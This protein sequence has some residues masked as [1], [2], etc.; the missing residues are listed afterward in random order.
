MNDVVI[1][2]AG[3]AGLAAAYELSLRGRHCVVLEQ[4]PRAGGVIFTERVDGFVID[5]GPDSL[6]VQ[7]PAA[8]DLAREIGLGDRLVETLKPR[9][10]YI[11]RDGRL[12]PLPEA[13][14]LGIPTT[15]RPFFTTRLFSWPAKLRMALELAIRPR[16][17]LDDESIGSFMRRRFGREA[18]TYLAEPL[19]AGIHAGDVDR[20]SMRALFPRLLEA[21]RTHGSVLRSVRAQRSSRPPQSAFLSFQGGLDEIIDGLVAKLPFGTLHLGVT[22]SRVNGRGPF[23]LQLSNGEV[24][25]TRVLIVATPARVAASLLRDVDAELALSCAALRYTSTAIVALGFRREQVK[26]PLRGSGFVVPRVERHLLMAG[27]W[28]TSKWPNRAPPGHVLLRGFV[29]GA[30]GIDPLTLTDDALI[31]RAADELTARLTIT[32]APVLS[33]VYRWPD[34]TAQHEV[35][36]H[37]WLREIETRLLGI[38]GLLLTGSSYRGTGI[39]DCVA[40]GRAV[41]A[42]A[43]AALERATLS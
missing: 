1:V 9:T 29:G 23:T 5:A 35:G 17:S 40:D 3:I 39:P 26:H 16:K 6:L 7:K 10:A 28:V 38:R 25:E 19:L 31:V 36:H 34:A 21:E 24:I 15:V 8:I 20:L 18:V 13:S 42:R 11:V 12:V 33:R 27:T 4:R 41:A 43:V 30:S 32:G 37:T 14:F 2:G 22:V